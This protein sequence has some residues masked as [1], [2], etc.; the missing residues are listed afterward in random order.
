MSLLSSFLSDFCQMSHEEPPTTCSF[1]SSDGHEK[2]L[3][4]VR[5]GLHH[6]Q[7]HEAAADQ[8]INA[9]PRKLTAQSQGPPGT[10]LAIPDSGPFSPE[11]PEFNSSKWA[12]VTYG[13][14]PYRRFG[15]ELF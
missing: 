13:I 8:E 2:T 6:L 12:K 11:S 15:G 14:P 5:S 10:L 3:Q 9:L 7:A 1:E 4:D